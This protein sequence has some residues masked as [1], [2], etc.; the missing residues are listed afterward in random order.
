MSLSPEPTHVREGCE[1][2]I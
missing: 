1:G 2:S